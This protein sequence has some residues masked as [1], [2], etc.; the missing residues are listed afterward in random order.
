MAQKQQKKIKRFAP[1]KNGP[2]VP[3]TPKKRPPANGGGINA[4]PAAPPAVPAVPPSPQPVSPAQVP[5]PQ[6][7]IEQSTVQSAQNPVPQPPIEQPAV[8]PV[9]AP[10]P[11]PVQ[12][13]QVPLQPQAV[14]Q[15]PPQPVAAPP[16]PPLPVM[17]PV[18]PPM[19]P[20]QPQV[21]QNPGIAPQYNISQGM[22]ESINMP[23]QAGVPPAAQVGQRT[24]SFDKNKK[25]VLRGKPAVQTDS[26][27][28]KD[29]VASYLEVCDSC[30]SDKT[31][32]QDIVDV[33]H[34]LVRSLNMDVL[35]IALLDEN[36]ENLIGNIA[37][38]GYNSPPTKSVVEC[39]NK[40]VIKGD[41]LNWKRLMKVAGDTHTELAYWIVHEGLDSIGY[42]PIRDSQT[43]YGFLFVASKESKKQS[44]LTSPLLDACGS[45]IGLM[46]ALKYNK[47]DWPQSI[48]DLGT[49]IRNQFSLIMGYMEMLKEGQSM[50][51]ENYHAIL[52]HCNRSIVESTQMLDS[53]TAEAGIN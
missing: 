13:Q 33:V 22:Q 11:I 21:P 12:P 32:P 41:G 39:W 44:A 8:Q 9:Y 10:Q 52:E 15:P 53:M 48:L 27:D 47:G 25:K 3:K 18:T 42:V 34:M 37:S 16:V 30:L 5:A 17:Q 49:G 36:K 19:V 51:P 40:A 31:D 1:K 20:Q 50:P 43:I 28:L 14:H 7:P 29:E 45:R 26:E 4:A 46:T 24:G 2:S 38:R 6:P 35:T 23:T